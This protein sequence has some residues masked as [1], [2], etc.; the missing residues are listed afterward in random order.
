M[1]LTV[2]GIACSDSGTPQTE[3]ATEV[4]VDTEALN[5]A[6]SG[7]V[8]KERARLSCASWRDQGS[9][10]YGFSC[11]GNPNV[12]YS[13]NMQAGA[14]TGKNWYHV[15]K[16]T[17]HPGSPVDETYAHLRY[18]QC[19]C[20]DSA[21]CT[22]ISALAAPKDPETSFNTAGSPAPEPEAAEDS[23]SLYEPV[24]AC[25]RTMSA[26]EALC[27]TT[28]GAQHGGSFTWTGALN[29]SWSANKTWGSTQWHIACALNG[30]DTYSPS[31]GGYTSV[32]RKCT[33]TNNW[34]ANS[35]YNLTCSSG[36]VPGQQPRESVFETQ[37]SGTPST[38]S[39]YLF[40]SNPCN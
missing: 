14:P 24:N 2:L 34:G 19:S 6:C 38:G 30:A 37:T 22:Q 18:D 5:G 8:A 13:F 9:A 12:S 20:N 36:G 33:M 16:R 11:G 1:I 23:V 26:W 10:V 15:Y 25:S 40:N 28:F 17:T 7:G 21:P 29:G 31:S 27:R 35:Q 39:R 3:Q 32:N 4:G